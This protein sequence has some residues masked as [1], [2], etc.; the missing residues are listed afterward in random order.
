MRWMDHHGRA[1]AIGG[2]CI[3]LR[4]PP[5]GPTRRSLPA[6]SSSPVSKCAVE[7]VRRR[8]GSTSKY[9]LPHGRSPRSG[10]GVGD[11]A[12]HLH[13]WSWDLPPIHGNPLTPGNERQSCFQM[14][15]TACM[16]KGRVRNDI[17]ESM[18]EI[19]TLRR[20]GW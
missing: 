3:E 1:H 4:P 2:A 18:S 6:M 15:R 20:G 13:L 8:A 14:R 5:A 9:P 17:P 11:H 12:T 16:P 10:G 19:R 7:T